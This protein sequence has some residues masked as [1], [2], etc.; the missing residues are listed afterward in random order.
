[1][2]IKAL[3]PALRERK[4]YVAFCVESDR[5]FS[6]EEVARAIV[7][8]A[9]ALFGET[10]V[11]EFNL[12]VLDFDEATQEGFV[13]CSH[14]SVANVIAALSLVGEISGDRVHLR[15]LGVSGTVKALKRKFLNR[16][17]HFINSERTVKFKGKEFVVVRESGERVDALPRDEEL[18][19]RLKF[20]K[21]RFI[22][23]T[24]SDLRGE[25]DAT[26]AEHGL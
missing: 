18:I 13:V 16:R 22:G 8:S 20:Q 9:L 23:V 21:M 12:F 17:R 10:K 25:E 2:K 6:R 1:M 26:N 14:R 7:S 11:A 24:K 5:P 15:S 19:E 3:P 4:R